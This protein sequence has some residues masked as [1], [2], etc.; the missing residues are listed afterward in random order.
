[1]TI[2]LDTENFINVSVDTETVSMSNEG[3]VIYQI[4]AVI[5]GVK[6]LTTI[7]GFRAEVNPRYIISAWDNETIQWQENKNSANWGAALDISHDKTVQ[8]MADN[9]RQFLVECEAYAGKPVR[10][11]FKGLDFDLPKLQALYA[12]LG[13]SHDLPWHYRNVMCARTLF[14]LTGYKMRTFNGAHDALNDAINQAIAIEECFSL[15]APKD[16]NE[17]G[18][19]GD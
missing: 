5:F 17:A 16:F 6:S 2:K 8:M 1:M 18:R 15:A 13:E 4:G 19:H 11:W 10:L 9:F 7:E 14:N 12:S 3:N